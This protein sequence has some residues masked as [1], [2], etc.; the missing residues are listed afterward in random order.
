MEWL[1]GGSLEEKDENLLGSRYY[2][3]LLQCIVVYL[4]NKKKTAFWVIHIFDIFLLFSF[5]FLFTYYIPAILHFVGM[6]K[7]YIVYLQRALHLFL[8]YQTAFPLLYTDMYAYSNIEY[9]SI[10]FFSTTIANGMWIVEYNKRMN[11]VRENNLCVESLLRMYKVIFDIQLKIH[12]H[13]DFCSFLQ[14][15]FYSIGKWKLSFQL[16]AVVVLVKA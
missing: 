11:K 15:V 6:N 14:A 13:S 2:V 16:S 3:L 4:L 8:Y 9:I 7:L 1:V 10:W 5:L 12:F